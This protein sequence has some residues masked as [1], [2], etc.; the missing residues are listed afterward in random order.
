MVWLEEPEGRP[1]FFDE[2]EGLAEK[3]GH[4]PYLI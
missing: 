3:P 1:L 4:R 2:H